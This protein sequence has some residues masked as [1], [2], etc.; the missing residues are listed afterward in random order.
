MKQCVRSLSIVLV[1]VFM[2]GC[3]A[4]KTGGPA[5]ST[6]ASGSEGKPAGSTDDPQGL[7][8]PLKQSSIG[9]V[10]L[11]PEAVK[12]QGSVPGR[13]VYRF[14]RFL[15]AELARFYESEMPDGE[16]FNGLAWCSRRVIP[17][18]MTVYESAWQVPG[19]PEFVVV[20]VSS[21]SQG[22][23]VAILDEKGNAG[24]SCG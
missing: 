5:G 22:A 9:A 16:P 1:V 19:V 21:D 23:F 13:E 7:A 2:A 6:A 11:L 3:G 12:D 20:Q 14:P 24:R 8:Q 17:G 10:P 4:S 15:P 18:T